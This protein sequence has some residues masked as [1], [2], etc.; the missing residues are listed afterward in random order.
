MKLKQDMV[1]INRAGKPEQKREKFVLPCYNRWYKCNSGMISD[2]IWELGNNLYFRET[3][4][5]RTLNF[6]IKIQRVIKIKT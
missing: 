5:I 4:G 1:E 2:N 3:V 6:L